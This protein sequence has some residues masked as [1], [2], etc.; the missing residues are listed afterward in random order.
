[1]THAVVQLTYTV[2]GCFLI[3]IP[4]SNYGIFVGKMAPI[5]IF[6]YFYIFQPFECLKIVQELWANEQTAKKFQDA[7]LLL[8]ANI[9]TFLYHQW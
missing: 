2:I 8:E 3:W 7:G 6:F 4:T 9:K 5:F 1:M